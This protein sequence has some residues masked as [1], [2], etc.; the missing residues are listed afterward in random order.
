[1]TV[2]F[3]HLPVRF[4]IALAVACA[5]VPAMAQ[6]GGG[7]GG[8]T[9]DGWE[10]KQQRVR[11]TPRVLRIELGGIQ[12]V[13]DKAVRNQIRLRPGDLLRSSVVAGDIGR[14]F[15]MGLF[16]DVRVGIKKVAGPG[17]KVIV[18]YQMLERPSIKKIS[19]EGN[20][21]QGKEAILK[22]VD[23]KLNDLYSPSQAHDNA[24]KIKELYVEEGFF[25]AT[26]RLRVETGQ[27]G[28]RHL[29]DR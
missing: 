4:A 2:G 11:V 1:M 21:E 14:I 20:D 24:N 18:R 8:L 23:L 12:R 6:L 17:D 16:D 27:S 28:S 26:V 10:N 3:R 15:Q 25:L 19:I 22:V 5:A 7:L 9:L 29:Q 13:D